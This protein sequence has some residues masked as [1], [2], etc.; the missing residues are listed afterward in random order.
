MPRIKAPSVAFLL[1]TFAGLVF[2][3]QFALNSFTPLWGDD[4][5][6]AVPAHEFPDIF[7]RIA[8]EYRTWGG[9]LWVLLLTFV[10]LLKYPGSLVLFNL[11]NSAVFCLLLAV[12]FR[13]AMGRWPGRAGTDLVLLSAALFA[14][15]FFTQCLGEVVFW[16]TG[17]V[18]Y[19]WTVTAA[20]YVIAPFV[21]LLADDE[22]LADTRWRL[23]GLPIVAALWAT[24]L[25]TLSLS[26]TIFMLYALLAA[27]IRKIEL[28]RWYW[29]VFGGQSAG[30]LLLVTSPGNWVRAARS[31]D[32]LGICYRIILLSRSVWHHV[33]SEVPIFYAMVALLVLLLLL[34]RRV[35]LQRFYLWLILGLMVAFAMAGSSGASFSQRTAF[36]SEICFI[37]ALLCLCGCLFSRPRMARLRTQVLLLPLYAALVGVLGADIM[38]TLE[39]Y[40]A[41]RQQTQRRQELM[42]AYQTQG[43]KHIL[44]PSMRIPFIDGLKDDI[45]EGRFFLRDLHTDQPGN[46]WR[47]G[48]FAAYHGFAFANRLDVAHV[49][50]ATELSNGGRFSP[51]GKIANLSIYMRREARGWGSGDAL[52]FIS[53]RP[54]FIDLKELCV[55]PADYGRLNFDDREQGCRKVKGK[56]DGVALVAAD[57]QPMTG[58]F[59]ARFELPD[60]E[61]DHIDFEHPRLPRNHRATLHMGLKAISQ[62]AALTQ[63]MSWRGIDLQHS[64]DALVDRRKGSIASPAGKAMEG[65]LNWG[66]YVTLSAGVYEFEAEYATAAPGAQWEVVAQTTAGP[67][68]LASG[69]LEPDGGA[70]RILQDGFTIPPELAAAPIEFRIDPADGERVELFRFS[71]LAGESAANPQ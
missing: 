23:W 62:D 15:W 9:R 50:C 60:W 55:V 33:T 18:G 40:L 56:A 53:D 65:Y 17:A 44:L 25:E 48:T 8:D 39:Q 57:G 1:A 22:P 71:I 29:H 70:P 24:G 49:I 11:V 34:R 28:H 42:A 2:A 43:L 47:N 21:D 3:L 52:Y 4:W 30:T 51:L 68:R 32:G 54:P 37:V 45:A 26:L 69:A 20:V 6:R 61:I 27:H 14:V 38:K 66:P 36:A 19:L 16:K 7:Q 13:G 59:V 12:V 35:A 31:D 41:V 63:A 67:R 64:A 5:W 46:A 58:R 10:F